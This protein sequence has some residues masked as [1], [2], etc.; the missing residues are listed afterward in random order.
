MPTYN[1]V[2]FF[3]DL[4]ISLGIVLAI[5]G[6]LGKVLRELLDKTIRLTAGSAFYL[7]ALI[8]ILLCGALSKVI[9]GVHQKPDD[10]FMDYVWAV[11]H[12]TSEVFDNLLLILIVYVV[13]VTV[14]VAVLRPKN[15]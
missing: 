7:R 1:A 8:L 5:Y 9:G 10:H 11:A 2:A 4:A 6:L 13:I 3:F 12:D 15:E 14:L